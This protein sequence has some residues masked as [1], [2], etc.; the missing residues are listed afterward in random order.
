MIYETPKDWRDLQNKVAR[1][2]SEIG[3]ESTIEESIELVRG[4]TK[5][6]VL[7]RNKTIQPNLLYLCECKHWN[8]NIPQSVVKSFKSDMTD[9]GAHLGFIISKIGFQSGCYDLAKKT[10]ILLFNWNEFQE[11]IFDEWYDSVSKKANSNSIDLRDYTDNFDT[12]TFNKIKK[13]S[14][15]DQKKVKKLQK[16]F[17][18]LALVSGLLYSGIFTRTILSKSELKLLIPEN[19]KLKEIKFDYY[20]DYFNCLQKWCEEG[21]DLFNEILD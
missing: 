21:I 1:I 6:D 5:V 19:G 18:P 15:I 16:D 11:K 2:F 12:H 17:L 14:K 20:G 8:T 3:Y 9:S 4:K 7:V 13:L 10:N